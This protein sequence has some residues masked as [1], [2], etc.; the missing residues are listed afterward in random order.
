M[1]V[2]MH[3]RVQDVVADVLRVA[4][5][6]IA[7]ESDFVQDLRADSLVLIELSMQLEEVFGIVRDRARV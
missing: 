7:F 5:A 4:P 2:S 3:S 1:Q 6:R